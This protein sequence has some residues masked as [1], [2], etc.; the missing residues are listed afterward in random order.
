MEWREMRHLKMNRLPFT[1]TTPYTPH[2]VIPPAALTLRLGN[3][4]FH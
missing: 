2:I 1:L 3:G 4:A